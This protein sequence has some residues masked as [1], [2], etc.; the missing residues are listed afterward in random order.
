MSRPCKKL[1]KCLL[2]K[3]ESQP[4][5]PPAS[6]LRLPLSPP[7]WVDE[8]LLHYRIYPE[9]CR[10]YPF[11]YLPGLKVNLS[12]DVFERRTS[13]GSGLFSF[14]SGI[15]VQIFGQLVS[16]LRKRLKNATLIWYC[17]FI[18]QWKRP[19]FRLTCVTHKRL[20]LL[21]F[22]SIEGWKW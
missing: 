1:V 7:W 6:H 16:I 20:C 18:L 9:V 4:Q 3:E 22:P 5:P 21:K 2:L 8:I 19:H 14:L 17:Q 11:I 12:K 10:L 15:F 13:T